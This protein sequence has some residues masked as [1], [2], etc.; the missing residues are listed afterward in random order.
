ML[1]NMRDDVDLVPLDD[2]EYLAAASDLARVEGDERAAALLRLRLLRKM[3]AARDQM[4]RV[5][6]LADEERADVVRELEDELIEQLIR[7]G[8]DAPPL[9]EQLRNVLDAQAAL[10]ARVVGATS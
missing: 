3:L 6:D 4:S 2:P 10:V 5:L 7:P 1:G 9:R 8:P